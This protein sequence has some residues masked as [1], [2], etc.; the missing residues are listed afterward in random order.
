MAIAQI[1]R[2]GL[3]VSALA[4]LTT[5]A[6]L[7][8]VYPQS[9]DPNHPAPLGPGV[10]RGNVRQNPG[11]AILSTFLRAPVISMWTW[12]SRRC[13]CSAR[14]CARQR[15]SRLHPNDT[16]SFAFGGNRVA[17]M[18]HCAQA[19]GLSKDATLSGDRGAGGRSRESGTG[20]FD[21]F[22]PQSPRRAIDLRPSS[23]GHI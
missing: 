13:A 5:F 7:S 23:V 16:P 10:N 15:H 3:G 19:R 2:R 12:R 14:R 9:T 20:R 6:V 11:R 21:R 18:K 17:M 1:L 8:G 22:R 4:A